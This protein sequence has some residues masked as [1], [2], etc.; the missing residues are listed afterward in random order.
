MSSFGLYLIGF[1][2]LAVGIMFA[3]SILGVGNQW[4]AVIGMVLLGL[5]V[6]TGV[7]KT[8]RRDAP[9][10]HTETHVADEQG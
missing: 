2:V 6:I 9:E 5:G 1:I 3:A 7:A 8:R 10:T 4:L